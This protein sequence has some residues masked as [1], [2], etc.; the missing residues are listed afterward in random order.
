MKE[1]E[2]NLRT[3]LE[4]KNIKI[5]PENIK[6]GVT[7]LGVTGTYTGDTPS[8]QANSIKIADEI[9]TSRP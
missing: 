2:T 8:P 1:L 3:I 9:L 4:E 6:S 7:I 5:I